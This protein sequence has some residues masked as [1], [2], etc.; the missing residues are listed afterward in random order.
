M[1]KTYYCLVSNL[2]WKLFVEELK[3]EAVVVNEL[4]PHNKMT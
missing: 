1:V 4:A 3:W 2:K